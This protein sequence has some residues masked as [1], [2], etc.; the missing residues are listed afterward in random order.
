MALQTCPTCSGAGAVQNVK[1]GQGQQCPACQGA[2]TVSGGYDDQD[3]F[4][5]ILP[6]ALTA[7]QLG[8]L[9]SVTIDNDADFLCDR[10]IASST[11][12]FSV[13][14]LD[15]FRSR[16]FQTAPINGE[17]IAGT[18]QLPLWLPNPFLIRKNAVIQGKFNDRSGAGNTIQ[19]LLVGRKLM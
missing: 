15:K 6:P 19:F 1:T 4:Y 14:L 17:N 7:N 12:L 8:V 13:E 10:F 18:A 9:A 11:G 5:P 16:P 3:F 2:G